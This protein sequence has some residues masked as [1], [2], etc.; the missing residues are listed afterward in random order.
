MIEFGQNINEFS[1]H[2]NEYVGV[3]LFSEFPTT[4]IFSDLNNDPIVKEWVDCSDNENINRSFYFKS[5]KTLLK[6]FI[7]GSLSHQDF[8]NNSTDGLL[9]FEDNL[10]GEIINKFVISTIGLPVEYMPSFDF[11]FK[12]EYGV[13]MDLIWNY[14]ELENVK[15]TK[16]NFEEIKDIA[17]KKN[18]ETYNLHLENSSGVGYGTID[19]EILGK[20][21]L[22][23]EKLYKDIS[24]D[25]IK[26]N[27]RG[28]ARYTSKEKEELDPYTSTQTYL[29]RAGSYSILIKPANSMNNLFQQTS[30]TQLIAVQLFNLIENSQS[31][32]KLML[33]YKK[34]SEF[35]MRSFKQFLKMIYENSLKMDLLW[36][37]PTTKKELFNKLTYVIANNI[38]LNIETLNVVDEDLLPLTGKFEAFNCNTRHF[39]FFTN[40]KE[41]F[42]GYLGREVDTELK[43]INFINLYKVE[44]LRKTV[45]VAGQQD[46]KISNTIVKLET[47]L[48]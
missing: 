32:E 7:E 13:E 19:T 11:F 40:T 39:E 24:L 41:H 10:K 36:F 43:L 5:N 14:F 2:L 25:F 47:D 38:L 12:S 35:A 37:N 9:Y 17:T 6:E 16:N 4:I 30:D 22:E 18:V 21:L 1:F 33:E 20:T 3:L 31:T 34:H 46:A 26:G 44:I 42:K 15:S 28:E 8:V 48:K 23:F 45:K 27:L 29:K